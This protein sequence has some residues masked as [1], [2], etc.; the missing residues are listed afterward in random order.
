MRYSILSVLDHYPGRPRTVGEFYEQVLVQGE[1]AEALGYEAYFVAEHHFHEYGAVPNPAVLLATMAQRTRWLRLGTAISVLT[2]HNPLMVAETY[3]MLDVLSGG[4]LVLGVGS[5][6]LKHEFEGFRIDPAEKRERFDEALE[7]LH[8]ALTGE[9]FSYRGKH[10]RI[11]NVAINVTPLQRPTPPIYVAVLRRE[12]AYH[13]GR[14]GQRIVSVPYAS[15]ESF[16]DIGALVAE[17]RKGQSDAGIAPGE[18]DIHIALHTHVAADDAQAKTRAA[19]PFDLYVATRLYAKRQNY[20]DVMRSGLSLIGGV[21]TVRRKLRELEA[22]GVHHIQALHN[23]GLMPQEQVLASMKR[24]A[25]LVKEINA[26]GRPAREGRV[27]DARHSSVAA[28][29]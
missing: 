10:I 9:R 12:A 4:R 11:D 24:F 19:D 25:E 15:V 17:Y 29:L 21:D 6:Y 14:K 8:K 16:D 22:M 5:G 1:L 20:D 7:V 27:D 3:A 26:Q 13:I 28:G 18:D 2:F 23:F